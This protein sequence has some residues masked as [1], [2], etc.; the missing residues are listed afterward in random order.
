MIAV[1]GF[2]FIV[3]SV[4]MVIL[5]HF[6][7]ISHSSLIAQITTQDVQYAARIIILNERV[8][9]LEMN[10]TRMFNDTSFINA[11]IIAD[12]V[13]LDNYTCDQLITINNMPN[14]CNGTFYIY[15][16]GN[17]TVHPGSLSNQ[18]IINGTILKTQLNNDQAIIDFITTTLAIINADLTL[19]NL[20]AVKRINNIT[21]DNAGN[22]NLVGL[23]GVNVTQGFANTTSDIIIDT[24]GIQN[25][26]SSLVN[27]LNE[28]Y[29]M[30]QQDIVNINQT[31][32]NLTG[33]IAADQAAISSINPTL[34]KNINGQLPVDNDIDI[35]G[36]PGMA[37]TNVVNGSLTLTNRGVV[38]LNS[39]NSG[40]NVN[41]VG[42]PGTGVS[43]NAS[44]VTIVNTQA[45]ITFTPCVV[46]AF[47]A[48]PGGTL[49]T[50]GVSP[51]GNIVSPSYTKTNPIC[52]DVFSIDSNIYDHFVYTQ[53]IGTWAVSVRV[54]F[55]M[56][57]TAPFSLDSTCIPPGKVC[58]YMFLAGFV[59]DADGNDVRGAAIIYPVTTNSDPFSTGSI[60]GQIAF[61]SDVT[62][63]ASRFSIFQDWAQN[64]NALP[65]LQWSGATV[66]LTATRIA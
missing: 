30:I 38:T 8:D 37:V 10:I 65:V 1:S 66:E 55:A 28:S 47:G 25:N 41:I 42:G 17:I 64:A 26:A 13:F 52:P 34:V 53:P 36:G 35:V 45:E 5:V 33:E 31:I 14:P 56:G 39:L 27:L 58:G 12:N 20:E 9:F 24:C 62:P 40:R 2:A 43:L 6:S 18:V 46:R 50:A 48:I 29:I 22:I 15:G 44:G 61:T 60:F 57:S 51:I 49:I 23:C 21:R 54:G 11:S 32:A 59:N 63:I 7:V 19:L 4:V 16:L 3:V